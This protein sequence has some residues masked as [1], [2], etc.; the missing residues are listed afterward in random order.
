M[1]VERFS[2]FFVDQSRAE[3]MTRFQSALDHAIHLPISRGI[4]GH[5]ASDATIV[6]VHD[7]C[8]DACF[9]KERDGHAFCWS[10]QSLTIAGEISRNPP[11]LT[12]SSHLPSAIHARSAVTVTVLS[13][14]KKLPNRPTFSQHSPLKSRKVRRSGTVMRRSEDP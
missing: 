10:C 1:S 7:A 2:L 8:E 6:K 9:D 3:L 11:S 14:T 4:A 5:T 12:W 13:N